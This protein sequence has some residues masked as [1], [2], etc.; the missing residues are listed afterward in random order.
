MPDTPVPLAPF[1]LAIPVDDIAAARRF[2][3]SA[4]GLTEGR[5]DTKWIDWNLYGHQLVTHEVDTERD[6][7]RSIAGTNPVDGH[8]VPVPHF[9]VVLTVPDFH[10]LAGKLREADIDFVIEPYVRFEGEPGEQWTMFFTDPAG[11]AL[12]FKA[13]ADLDQLFAK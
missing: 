9:G 5:S 8:E 1:H 13:F 4:L 3:G 11:N 6:T 7:A 10:Q 12:E 2:Y